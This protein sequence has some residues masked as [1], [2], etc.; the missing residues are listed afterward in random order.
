MFA[1][2]LVQRVVNSRVPVAGKTHH[3]LYF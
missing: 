2:R 1:V 3:S